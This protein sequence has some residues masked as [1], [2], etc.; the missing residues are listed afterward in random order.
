MSRLFDEWADKYDHDVRSSD[1]E[2]KY[3]FAGYNHIKKLISDTILNTNK[4]YILEMG[5]GTGEITKE[6]YSKGLK[7]VGVD[8]SRKM[9]EEAKLKMP[10]AKFLH[11]EFMASL[12][13]L[14]TYD[15]II[16]N[17]SIHHIPYLKQY[18]LLLK[19][20]QHLRDGGMIILGDVMTETSFEMEKL[21]LVYKD[22][23]DDEEFYPTYEQYTES[24]LTNHYHI[25]CEIVSHCG[26]IMYLKKEK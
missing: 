1:E 12:D 10:N 13:Y 26:G 11:S 8:L 5:V 22:I 3:P 18:D 4:N 9:I 23:W 20:K 14:Q 24:K 2:N 21:S 16:F 19:L 25:T 17:Y 6:L 7:I 15:F